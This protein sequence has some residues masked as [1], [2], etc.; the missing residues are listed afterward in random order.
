M[1]ANRAT[2]PSSSPSVVAR[3]SECPVQRPSHPPPQW[4]SL[5]GQSCPESQSRPQRSRRQ[6]VDLFLG[7]FGLIEKVNAGG[8]PFEGRDHVPTSLS[9]Y[10]RRAALFAPE[11]APRGAGGNGVPTGRRR[12]ET[13]RRRSHPKQ[14]CGRTPRSDRRTLDARSLRTTSAQGVAGGAVGAS[15]VSRP[16][17]GALW[18]LY[19][20]AVQDCHPPLVGGSREPGY[21]GAASLWRSTWTLRTSSAVNSDKNGAPSMAASMRA[22]PPC[23]RS[24]RQQHAHHPHAR[25]ARRLNRRKGRS[26]RGANVVDHHHRRTCGNKPPQCDVR[27][28]ASSPPCAPE[29][30]A[31]GGRPDQKD[32]APHRR[33]TAPLAVA[34]F[35]T[36]GSA[37]IVKPPTARASG[38][39]SRSSSCSRCPA[40]RPP[41]ACSVVVRQ[42]M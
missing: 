30:H 6:D 7:Q 41:S 11:A 15:G 20:G 23:W 33:R 28:R 37:P 24:T 34:T 36:S 3:S 31:G 18:P 14:R 35:E 1:I 16:L 29:T 5:R 13:G 8:G 40:R 2:S 4:P 39:C 38:R 32:Q 42:S 19:G 27:C 12:S 9:N 25:L 26:A 22:R 21:A 10:G 17:L